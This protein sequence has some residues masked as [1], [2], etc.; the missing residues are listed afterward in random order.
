VI[1]VLLHCIEEE[2][3]FSVRC[4]AFQASFHYDSFYLKYYFC[5]TDFTVYINTLLSGAPSPLLLAPLLYAFPDL[6][7]TGDFGS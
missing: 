1:A 7:M 2:M 4:G 3:H 6:V 5:L